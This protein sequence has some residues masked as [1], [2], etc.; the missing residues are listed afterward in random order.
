MKFPKEFTFSV[1]NDVPRIV[2]TGVDLLDVV[3]NITY[4]IGYVYGKF[5][6]INPDQAKDFR[7][8]LV[9]VVAD[10]DSPCWEEVKATPGATEICFAIPKEADDGTLSEHP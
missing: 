6:G 8:M 2:I 5:K 3:A 4:L 10:P 9:Q 1:K 7:E